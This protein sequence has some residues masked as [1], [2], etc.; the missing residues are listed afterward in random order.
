M[1]FIEVGETM[2]FLIY[3]KP[4]LLIPTMCS[5]LCLTVRAEHKGLAELCCLSPS[6][7]GCVTVVELR[8]SRGTEWTAQM[9]GHWKRRL[10]PGEVNVECPDVEFH[11]AF[12]PFR[13]P[14][15][16]WQCLSCFQEL[17]WEILKKR[18]PQTTSQHM[19]LNAT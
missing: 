11:T 10:L 13:L 2:L 7:T 8:A 4:Y 17:Q 1:C 16:T 9:A 19:E 12:L 5:L 14:Q 15:R 18:V 6:H 3:R